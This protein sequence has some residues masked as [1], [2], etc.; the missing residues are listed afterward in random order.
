MKISQL[1]GRLALILVPAFL[2]VLIVI[3]GVNVPF[4]DEWSMP[5]EF[6]TI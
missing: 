2:L 6:L 4:W 5:G 1:S 3:N